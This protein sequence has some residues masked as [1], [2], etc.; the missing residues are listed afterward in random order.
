MATL[1]GGIYQ[2]IDIATFIY[3]FLLG[4]LGKK[5]IIYLLEGALGIV[6]YPLFYAS[7]ALWMIDVNIFFMSLLYAMYAVFI[8]EIYSSIFKPRINN[9]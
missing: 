2:S 3:F 8:L 6:L 9:A 1:F 4:F 5:F 7:V